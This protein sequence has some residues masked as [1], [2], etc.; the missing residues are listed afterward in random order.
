MRQD[1]K[2]PIRDI[3]TQLNGFT[4]KLTA[5][6]K[7]E[8]Q[9]W[10][11]ERAKQEKAA[12]RIET[13]R[14]KIVDLL[15]T[16]SVVNT[17]ENVVC[18]HSHKITRVFV[19]GERNSGTNLL[20]KALDVYLGKQSSYA[21]DGYA[22]NPFG[23]KHLWY[24]IEEKSIAQVLPEGQNNTLWLIAARNPCDWGDGMYRKPHHRC[25]DAGCPRPWT[26]IGIIHVKTNYSREEF[27]P[28][29]RSV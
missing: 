21:P 1:E 8:K 17:Q 28:K 25:P 18:R 16:L 26:K 20:V 23:F 9:Q 22:N 19:V 6:L 29:V 2:R 15:R 5:R 24:G 27:L 10:N 11:E 4:R 7:E 13:Q 14:I 12:M 3:A